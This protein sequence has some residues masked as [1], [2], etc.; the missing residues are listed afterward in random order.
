[1][2]A[3]HGLG[4]AR[5]FSIVL[6]IFVI[7]NTF[8]MNVSERRR[9]MAIMRAIGATRSQIERLLIRESLLLGFV[10]AVLGLLLGRVLTEV[11]AASMANVFQVQ[12]PSLQWE[13]QAVIY[14][15]L[16]GPGMAILGAYVPAT[17]GRETNADGR[18]GLVYSSRCEQQFTVVAG[19]RCLLTY[20]GHGLIGGQHFQLAANGPF[21]LGGRFC[22]NRNGVCHAS[23]FTAV[24]MVGKLVRTVVLSC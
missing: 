22:T 17:P 16:F 15:L 23:R 8:F 14:A 12:L 1:M 2:A 13:A 11:L 5:A 21:R 19:V 18:D 9:P 6:A 24:D 10:G 4:M 3:Q 7:M 20:R